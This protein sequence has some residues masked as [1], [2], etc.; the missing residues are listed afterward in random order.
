MGKN[1][2]EYLAKILDKLLLFSKHYSQVDLN[3]RGDNI[4]VCWCKTTNWKWEFE[5]I[6][7]PHTDI[8]IR[9]AHYK[10]KLGYAFKNRKI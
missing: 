4:E 10:N 2:L 5:K 6:E 8:D 9:I 3:L 1:K 7:F